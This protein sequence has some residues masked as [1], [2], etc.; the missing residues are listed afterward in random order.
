MTSYMLKLNAKR[1]WGHAKEYVEYV[2]N[3]SK[4]NVM[5]IFWLMKKLF[6][7]IFN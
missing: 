3:I 6:S 4:R 7:Q 5:I 1:D 2:E